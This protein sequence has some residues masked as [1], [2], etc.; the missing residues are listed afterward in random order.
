MLRSSVTKPVIITCLVLALLA[1]FDGPVSAAFPAAFIEMKKDG[2][3]DV[4]DLDSATL[5]TSPTVYSDTATITTAVP[6]LELVSEVPSSSGIDI[7]RIHAINVLD[8]APNEIVFVT[9]NQ[10]GYCGGGTPASAWKM[11]LD[12]LTGDPISLVLKQSL[13]LIQEVRWALFESSDGTL[14]TGGGWCGPKPPYYSTDHGETWQPANIGV[15][16]PNSTFSF[17]E[18]N[19]DVYAGT[20]YSPWHGQVYR[21]LGDAGADYWELVLDVALPRSIIQTM[22]VY[23]DQLFVGSYVYGGASGCE[24]SV[25]VYVSSDGNTFNATTGIPPCYSVR[26]LLVVD[27]Q[28]IAWTFNYPDATEYYVVRWNNSSQ[29]WEEISANRP[30]WANGLPEL[31]AYDGV[32]YF[33]GHAPGD[34]SA[35]I[36]QSADLGQTWQQ[37][38]ILQDPDASVMTIHDGILYIGTFHDAD[39]T[40]FIYRRVLNAPVIEV[41]P[42]SLEVT[43]QVGDVT[44]QALTI[45]NNGPVELT[46]SIGAGNSLE[47]VLHRLNSGYQAVIDII[48]N[49]YDFEGG[50][51]GTDIN[52]GSGRR[53]N[54]LSTNLGE[55]IEYSNNT[56]VNSSH[57]GNN[58]RYFTRKYPGLFVLVADIEGVDNLQISGSIEKPRDGGNVDGT[59]LQTD[60]Y[61]VTYYGFV[62]RVY[63]GHAYPEGSIPS[64]NHLIIVADNPSADHTFFVS[65][66]NDDHQ[67][68]NLSQ[69]TRLYYLLYRGTYADYIDDEATLSIMQTFLST[70]ELFPPSPRLATSPISGTVPAYSS[71]PVQVTF[72]AGGVQP[73][74]YTTQIVIRSNDPVTPSVSIPVSMTVLPTANMGW[75]EGTVTD[76]TTGDPLAAS[77]LALGQPYTATTDPDTGTYKLWLEA[78]SYTM[79]VAAEGY[80]TETTAVDIVAQQGTTQ[81]FALVLNVP[82]IGVS[83]ESLEVTH[84]VGDVTMQA[85]TITNNGPAELTFELAEQG[86]VAYYPFNGNADDESGN[87]NYGTVQGATLTIDRFGKPN[88][89]YSFDGLD[90]YVEMQSPLTLSEFTFSLWIK[91]Q[92][93]GSIDNKI[94]YTIND[95]TGHQYGLQGNSGGALSIVVDGEEVNEFDWAFELDVWT[96]IVVTFDGLNIKLY[97]DGIL[98]ETWAIPGM[99]ITGILIIGDPQSAWDGEIDDIRIYNR[100]LSETEIQELY[101]WPGGV[102]VPWLTTEPISGTVSAYSSTPVQVTFDATS[103]QPDTYTTPIVIR[104]NDPLRPWISVPVSM[105]V[106]PTANMGWI[107]GTVTD[108]ATGDPLAASVVALSQPYTATTDPATGTYKLW[109]EAGSYTMQV[110]AEGYLT[111]TTAVDIVAQQG[112]TQDFALTILPAIIIPCNTT[113]LIN[114]INVANSTGGAD[115]LDL[116]A[117]CTYTLTEV[118][119]DTDG[120]NGLPSITSDITIN[121]NGATIERSRAS[122]TPDFRIFHVTVARDLTLNEL[123][124]QNGR[125]SEGGGGIYCRHCSLNIDS[126]IIKDNFCPYRGSGGGIAVSDGSLIMKNSFLVDNSAPYNDGGGIALQTSSCKIVNSVIAGNYSEETGGGFVFEYGNDYQIINSIIVGNRTPN[127]IGAAVSVL[128]TAHVTF[129]NCIFLDNQGST[130]FDEKYCVGN[131]SITLNHSNTFNNSPDGCVNI[132]RN[133]CLGDPPIDGVDPLFVDPDN[134]DFHLQPGSL[135]IDAGDND[136]PELPDI[137]LEGNPRI[138]DGDNDEIAVVDMGAFE[139]RPQAM[140]RDVCVPQQMEVTGVGMGNWDSAINPQS[141]ALAD[142]AN[143][144]WLMAQ[145]VGRNIPVP[146]TVVFSSDAPQSVT[147]NQPNTS[148]PHGYGFETNLQPSDQITVSVS[149]LGNDYMTPRGLVLYSKRASGD[150]WTSIGATTNDYVWRK[151]DDTHTEV[152]TLPS[153]TEATDLYVTAVVIDNDDDARPMVVEAVAGG[154]TASVSETGPTHGPGLNIVELTLAQVLTGTDQVSVTLRSPSE[155]GDSLVLVGLNVSYPCA[156]TTPYRVESVAPAPNSHAA[157]ANTRLT[158]TMSGTVSQTSVT[159]QTLFVHGGFQGHLD[160]NFNFGSTGVYSNIVFDPAGDFHPG[161][162]VETSLTRDIVVGSMPLASPYVWQF[163]TAVE[164]GSGHF[165]DSGQNLGSFN[166]YGVALGDVD[167]DGDLDAFGGNGNNQPDKV[168]LNDGT[169]IFSDSGQNL[170][171]LR[172]EGVDLGDLDGDGDLDAFVTSWGQPN[173]VWLNDGTGVFA[174]NGQNLGNSHSVRVALGDVDGDRDLDAFVGNGHGEPNLVWLND[175]TGHFADSTQRL[176]NVSTGH[177]ALGDLDGDGDLDAFVGNYGASDRVWLNNGTGVFGDSGQRLGSEGSLGVALGDLD[178]DGDLDAFVVH[179]LEQQPDEVWLNDGRGYFTDS[180]QRLGNFVSNDVTLGDLDGDGDLDAVIGNIS[181]Q[182]N[183]V[184]LND[185]TGAFIDSG[186]R[187]GNSY[188]LKAALGDLDSDG[189]LDAFVANFGQANRVW[190]NQPGVFLTPPVQA[191]SD[192]A[193]ST[194]NFT[195]W[196]ANYTGAVDSFDLSALGNTWPTSLSIDNTGALAH[197]ESVSFTAQVEIPSSASHG[198]TDSVT[199]QATSVTSPTGYSDTATLNT[200]AV[201]SCQVWN[202]ASDFRISPNQE[203]PNRDSCDSPDVWYFMQSTG[204]NRDPQTYSLLPNFRSILMG[205]E[206]IQAWYGGLAGDPSFSVAINATGTPQQ[207]NG[208]MWPPNVIGMHPANQR[209]AIVGWHSPLT[210]SVAITGGVSD[211]DSQCGDGVLWYIDKDATNL[212]SGSIVNGGSQNFLS[213]T[214]G[215]SLGDIAV[216]Q[217][218]FIYV[219]IHPNTEYTCDSTEVDLTIT[220]NPD[221]RLT[222]PPNTHS[223]ATD[224]DLTVTVSGA[225]SQTSVTPQ[226]LFVHGGF[227]GH[228]DGNFNFGSTGVYSDIVFDPTGD[229][230]PGELVETSLTTDIVVGGMSLASPYVWQF[231]TA[232]ESGSGHFVDSG[233]SLGSSGSETVVF[234]DLDG[235]GDLD[236]FVANHR[237]HANK[238]WLNDGS[239]NFSET[240]Q[241]L[242][243]ADSVGLALGDLDGDGDLDAFVG[244]GWNDASKVWLNDGLANFSNSGQNLTRPGLQNDDVVALGDLDGDGDL[245]AF[246][247]NQVTD[248]VWLNDGTGTFTDSNQNLD[249]SNT[250]GVA[251]GDVDGDGDLD[252]FVANLSGVNQVWLNNGTGDLT[253]TQNLGDSGSHSVT[254]GDVDGDG[255]LDAFVA[256]R[257]QANTVW[258]NNGGIQGGTLGNFSDSGQSLG[259]ARSEDVAL[260]DVDGDGD[261]DAF[262]A[263][264]SGPNIVW[265]NNGAGVFNDS[266]QSLGSSS[267][268]GGVA[269]G[270]VDGDGDLDAFIGNWP[271]QA[272]KVWLNQPAPPPLAAW[273]DVCVPHQMEITGIGMGN[274]DSAINPQSLALADPANVNWLMAQMVGRNIPVPDTVVFSSDAPQSVTLNQPNTSAPHGYGFETSLQPSDQITVSVSNP[275][276]DYMTP[277]GLVLYSKRASGDEWTSI[278]TTTND[279]IWRKLDDTH[280][281]VLTLPPLTEAT[282]LYVTAVVIDNDDDARPMVVEAVAG[283]ITA[284]VS[285]TGPTHGPGLNIVDLTLAQVLT[286]TDQVSVTLHSPSDNGDSL[287]LVGLNVSYPCTGG[288]VPAHVALT[289]G[290][291]TLPA[292]GQSTAVIIATVSNAQGNL[293]ADNTLVG[294]STT[295][296][297]LN[298]N[299][300]PT[301]N[302]SATATLKSD[303]IEGVAVVT[304]S[305]GEVQESIE[306]GF[307]IAAPESIIYYLPIILK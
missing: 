284:S 120:S 138:V 113:E 38:A 12:P 158:V 76:A 186:Q 117:D 251:L 249:G 302:G 140:W 287:V 23:E 242:G 297:T 21:W 245:D 156:K 28:L 24:S 27:E 182:A 257:G 226:T 215:N 264:L 292:D 230:H 180:D 114:A 50:E 17:V 22:V 223:A 9:Q 61:G 232:V 218:E 165:V 272:N 137:D 265:L 174:D 89:A 80:L 183:E 216:N 94:P 92:M 125:A 152:L 184:L 102:D 20:G 252:A 134:G 6:G 263:N 295:L 196:L 26:D 221:V 220:L 95:G 217:G 241:N 33:Y 128:N 122:G 25:P 269:M 301:E 238:V 160:G 283:D 41:S 300:A 105:T 90:D 19:G 32:I 228:V 109:L 40:A 200:A 237:D 118:D 49:R 203:N 204:L 244:N 1:W 227:Q 201:G 159:T 145:M 170:G 187:L 129:T 231:R 274:R 229:F 173:K 59:V 82:E 127:A 270:D 78:G 247:G 91:T 88:S 7:L 87:G 289:A 259:S 166:S 83:P 36:Y 233:Q 234:G 107:E 239:G 275:G 60:L 279:Y 276:N 47:N 135:C 112:T 224:T 70:L 290:S 100:V 243:S 110:A 303:V 10:G 294:F 71:T 64:V 3:G 299:V 97:K 305:A 167:G 52:H 15:H 43:H 198:D 56:I 262:V 169:G 286:G 212:A 13:S 207:P 142:P 136:A 181:D 4:D 175:G 157:A 143:V 133:Y 256:N 116:A 93:D 171:N 222:P 96:H 63:G 172:S 267:D 75:I 273:S 164:S 211:M 280:T 281:E 62:K 35:G 132:A 163:R 124:V 176:G 101:D 146:D 67:V 195:V 192:E 162:L 190:L 285:E 206:D 194:I 86:L 58:G 148:A 268:S 141:L 98:T 191:S 85:L 214:G 271:D 48:P 209:L 55:G 179:R 155:N 81:D 197:G 14:F 304:V 210:G 79:Q 123:T 73:D 246:V 29:E 8:N 16:P 99:P 154:I 119:N 250:A 126:S 205:I 104:S 72:D 46:F 255:D 277:R 288:N 161:E 208:I 266:G 111:E 254:L 168:W 42:E 149:N 115:T 139:F 11:I 69:N 258:L 147:L 34:A 53:G 293:V 306:I 39:N 44:V 150:E 30:D 240:G 18:F 185:G 65:D 74:T 177:V 108:A 278:G 103:V 261:L 248:I 2:V 291:T 66:H 225:V 236:A 51:T 189:D 219:S 31:V 121:G 178:G 153:L 260:G 106:L 68:Y 296:G 77:V 298:T 131:S 282:D 57:F 45:A 84:Q 5:V 37:I 307:E 151:L 130:G 213:G 54:Y 188:S 235:D 253:L 202:L 144:N 199:I 193:D